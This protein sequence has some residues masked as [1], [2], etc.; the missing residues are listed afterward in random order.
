M[1]GLAGADD[2]ASRPI[3]TTTRIARTVATGDTLKSGKITRR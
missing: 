1:T 2:A 3:A